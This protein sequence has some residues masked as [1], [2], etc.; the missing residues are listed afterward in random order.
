MEQQKR[1]LEQKLRVL[2][3]T[4]E[5]LIVDAGF[6]KMGCH[7]PALYRKKIKGFV[8]PFHIR[9]KDLNR[10]KEVKRGRDTR[11]QMYTFGQ[12]EK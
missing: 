12:R 11:N 4:S 2:S 3:Q 8:L 10:R 7:D 1:E 9:E 6:E 5:E